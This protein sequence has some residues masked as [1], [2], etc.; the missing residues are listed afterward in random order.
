MIEGLVESPSDVL[1][2]RYFLKSNLSAKQFAINARLHP[3]TFRS[4]LSGKLS[5]T[6]SFI[7]RLSKF[8]QTTPRYWFHLQLEYEFQTYL[9]KQACS[10]IAVLPI[11][12]RQAETKN[13]PNINELPSKFETPGEHFL[14]IFLQPEKLSITR[15]AK[16]LKMSDPEKVKKL[17]NGSIEFDYLMAARLACRFGTSVHY[18]LRLQLSYDIRRFTA[19]AKTQPK[20]ILNQ[21]EL[22]RTKIEGK[23]WDSRQSKVLIPGKVLQTNCLGLAKDVKLAEWCQL[24]LVGQGKLKSILLGKSQMSVALVVKLCLVFDTPVDYWFDMK[25]RYLSVKAESAIKTKQLRTRIIACRKSSSPK[26][27][28]PVYPNPGTR[29]VESYLNPLNWSVCAFAR[30]IGVKVSKLN[31]L[32]LGLAT[33]DFGLALKLGKALEMDPKYWLYLQL[34]HSLSNNQKLPGGLPHGI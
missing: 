14:K 17:V 24:L 1:K 6:A 22:Y 3:T 20:T 21:L 11:K 10:T 2:K 8:T 13:P 26:S 30:H 7:E 34:D 29:L 4:V 5:M 23:E 32:R 15:A 9:K 25:L 28:E 31:H 12:K 27:F 18:W 16:E 33:I 19:Q